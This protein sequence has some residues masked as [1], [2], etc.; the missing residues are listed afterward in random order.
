MPCIAMLASEEG[1]S[2]LRRGE[3]EMSK[4]GAGDGVLQS[5]AFWPGL[6]RRTRNLSSYGI[7]CALRLYAMSHGIFE[8]PHWHLGRPSNVAAQ[9]SVETLCS[10][11]EVSRPFLRFRLLR[12]SGPASC[13][14][15]TK[16]VRLC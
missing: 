8:H 1:T 11:R 10:L 15:A 6:L 3:V 7:M 13:E 4:R 5:R 14:P 12:L 16:D 2:K 9:S